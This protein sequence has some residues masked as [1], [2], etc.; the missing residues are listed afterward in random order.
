MKVLVFDVFGKYALFRRS[1]TTTS[2]TS[3]DFPPRTAICG[4]MGAVL[5]ITNDTSDSSKHL[6]CFDS[7]HIAIRLLKPIRKVN[8]AV[9]YV[10]TKSGKEAPRTQIILELIKEPAYRIYI[11][12]FELFYQLKKHLED[13]VSIFTPYLGQAQMLANLNFVGVYEAEEIS[14]PVEVHSVI[15][16]IQGMKLEPQSGMVIVKERMTVNMDNERRPVAFATYWVEKNAK[17]LKI[18]QYPEKIYRIKELGENIC[19][20]D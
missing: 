12:E 16:Q 5:G 15:K 13:G 4:L 14:P 20:M 6:R 11:S 3:Y 7:A 19:W 8:L 17:A 1:Y 18:V 9:N 10:E 2:S